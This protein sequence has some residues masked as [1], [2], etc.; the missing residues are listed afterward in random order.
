MVNRNLIRTLENDADLAAEIEAAMASTDEDGLATAIATE[1][2]VDVNSIVEGKVIR[3]DDGRVIVDVGFK[4]EGRIPLNEWEE[5]EEQPKAG[6]VVQVLVEELDDGR[7][8][9]PYGM[10]TL[11]KRKAPSL[12]GA[13][14][15]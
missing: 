10:I 3:I 12:S 6:D 14:Y 9:D 15:A 1:Q 13:A 7:S 8:D 4:S 11:S 2:S 5:E